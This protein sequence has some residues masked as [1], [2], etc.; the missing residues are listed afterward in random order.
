MLMFNRLQSSE[1]S[2]LKITIIYTSLQPK[3]THSQQNYFA[4]LNL[5]KQ[6]LAARI[7]ITQRQEPANVDFSFGYS[8]AAVSSAEVVSEERFHVTASETLP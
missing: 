7:P 2:P 1:P 5:F 3:E 4:N 8:A 6:L